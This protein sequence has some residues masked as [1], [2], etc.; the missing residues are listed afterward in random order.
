MGE[1][2][3]R[4]GLSLS[5]AYPSTVG[6]E[7]HPPATIYPGTSPAYIMTTQIPRVPDPMDRPVRDLGIPEGMM[8]HHL[9]TQIILLMNM[10]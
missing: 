10:I 1:F 2:K 5:T 9:L 3:G 8:N 4:I 6:H 7:M